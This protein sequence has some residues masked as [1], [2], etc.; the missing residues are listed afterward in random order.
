[1]VLAWLTNLRHEFGTRCLL[2]LVIY[3]WLI[4]G[5]L[6]SSIVQGFAMQYFRMIHVNASQISV[7]YSIV[8]IPFSIKSLFAFVSDYTPLGGYNKRYYIVISSLGALAGCCVLAFV[9]PATLGYYGAVLAYFVVVL[10]GAVIDILSEGMYSK[11]MRTSAE[12]APDLMAFVWIGNWIF[13]SI[14]QL[15]NGLLLQFFQMHDPTQTSGIQIGFMSAIPVAIAA[16]LT[17]LSTL[18]VEEKVTE[19][20]TREARSRFADQPEILLLA[21]ML[22]VLP[23]AYVGINIFSRHAKWL[24]PGVN[25]TILCTLVV[26]A[27]TS[28]WFFLRPLIGRY[29]VFS[30]MANSLALMGV[31]GA[32]DSFFLD[33]KVQF[34]GGPNFSSFFYNTLMPIAGGVMAVVA[35]SLY[36]SFTKD[37]KYR[38]VYL[39][40]IPLY[41]VIS[42]SNAV[43]YARLNKKLGIDDHVFC[44]GDTVLS[45]AAGSLLQQPGFLL[46]AKT[47]PAGMEA[48]I[49]ALMAG[50]ANF[51]TV[52]NSSFDA[53]LADVF[54]VKPRA[55]PGV[56]ESKTFGNMWKMAVLMNM[57]HF[58]PLL[59]LWLIP[60]VQQNQDVLPP[61]DDSSAT[62]GSP[63][64]RC[65]GV[66]AKAPEDEEDK[67]PFIPLPSREMQER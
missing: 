50:L 58:V 6:I 37:W 8:M 62:I 38:F 51:A 21:I 26:T 22:G 23:L 30:A 54:G 27:T 64:Q 43:I 19:E 7:A 48:T 67:T 40:F 60:N 9:T 44:F 49:Y 3:Q 52:V 45:A 65:Q 59:F 63:F 31:S 1:M 55:L 16:L 5:Y 2:M 53:Y 4:K 61:G 66:A 11:A 25:N 36:N 42:S 46:L 28:C 39:F 13:I 34:P 12:H 33:D 17:S 32:V 29:A 15:V 47:A 24:T 35:L 20:E 41:T 57:L 10:G 56:D 14:G 18:H